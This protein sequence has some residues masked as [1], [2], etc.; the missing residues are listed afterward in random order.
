[1]VAVCFI[2]G[3]TVERHR[4]AM[5]FQVLWGIDAVVA[6]IFVCFFIIGL[7][8]GSVSS[9]NMGLWSVIL[10]ALAALLWGS[11]MLRGAG[12]EVLATTLLTVLAVPSLQVG[13]LFLLILILQPKWN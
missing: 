12:K 3:V 13:L 7:A 6:A 10:G 9:F 1:M 11:Q 8:D 5:K 4:Y 2:E